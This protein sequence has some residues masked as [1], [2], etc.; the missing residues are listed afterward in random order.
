MPDRKLH[1]K[2][3]SAHLKTPSSQQEP[4]HLIYLVSCAM[5][6]AQQAGNLILLW[7]PPPQS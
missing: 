2:P 4:M 6:I 1:L 7:A 3:E 5:F